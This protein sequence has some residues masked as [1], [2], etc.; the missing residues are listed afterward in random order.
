[1]VHI[2]YARRLG[3]GHAR[4]S[5]FFNTAYDKRREMALRKKGVRRWT[6]QP[7]W[8][9]Y[10]PEVMERWV[11]WWQMKSIC[12]EFGWSWWQVLVVL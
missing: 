3:K 8:R 5:R 1:M 4:G 11:S 7:H 10:S 12:P 2:D 9:G 6:V